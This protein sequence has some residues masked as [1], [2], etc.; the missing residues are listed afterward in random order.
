MIIEKAERLKKLPPYLFVEIDNKKRKLLD[1]G[2]DVINLGIGDPDLPTPKFIIDK[3]SQAIYEPENH[4][5]PLQWGVAEFREQAAMWLKTRFGIA[6]FDPKTEILTVIGSKEAI[7]HMPLA[8]VNPGDVVLVPEPGYPVYQSAS[9]FAGGEVH[10]MPLLE[11]NNFLPDF[12]KIPAEVRKRAKL[13]FLNYPNNPTAAVA[14]EKFF[15]RAVQF[16]KENEIIIAHDAA[17]TEVYFEN[18]PVSIFNVEGAGDVAIE[19]HSLSKT[20]NMTGWRLGFAVGNAD[21]V[22]ALAGIKSNVDSGQFNAI[23]WAGVEALKN[24]EQTEV[25]ALLDI[26]KQRRD[27]LVEGLQ[28]IGLSVPKPQATFY[29]WGK[30]P[31][32][33]D[34]MSFCGKVLEEAHVV[35]IPG[36][37]FG[38]SGDGYF[39]AAVTVDVK[40]I[41]EAVERIGKMRN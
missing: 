31:E 9:I 34:S 39:R 25:K 19:F 8:V 24:A 18:R 29:V 11:E 33:Q 27:C 32:G 17:Y 38:P 12:G 13:M 36:V 41:Q 16:A 26:Y 22:S 35:L 7:G 2:H 20:F 6:G 1:A 3:M 10:Q 28:S 4:R 5:Y 37:G 15:E 23:Q 14:D 21:A 30:C 40:R